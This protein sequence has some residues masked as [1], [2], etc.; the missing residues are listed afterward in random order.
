MNKK[1]LFTAA[2][3][4]VLGGSLALAGAQTASAQVAVNPNDHMSSL[5]QKIANRFGLNKDE[6]QAVFEQDRQERHAE[7]E[8]AYQDYLTKEVSE[9]NITE[10]QKQLILEKR[11][12][13]EAKREATMESF[14]NMSDEERKA[15]MESE[16]ASLEAWAKENNVDLKYLGFFHVKAMKAKGIPG[17]HKDVFIMK[18]DAAGTTEVI[19]N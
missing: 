15:A 6:V 11:A 5:A 7:M 16:R 19:T 3:V 14:K 4:T 8:K 18:T 10:S 9:G 2:A 12:E 13:L 1:V 17:D